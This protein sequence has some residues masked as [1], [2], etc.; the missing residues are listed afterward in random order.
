MKF[1]F[2]ILFFL[3]PII[4]SAQKIERKIIIENGN[5]YFTTIDEEFQ[6]ATLHQ[7]KT[8]DKLKDA[9]HFALPAGRNFDAPVIPFSWDISNGFIYAINFLVHPLNDRNEALKKIKLSALQQWDST[10][11]VTNMLMTSVDLSPFAMND[12]YLFTVNRKNTLSNFYFDGISVNDST[13]CMAITNNNE[14][15]IWEWTGTMWRHSEPVNFQVDGYFSLFK[16]KNKIYA[17][18]RHGFIHEITL[19]SKIGIKSKKIGFAPVDGI[20]IDNRDKKTIQFLNN[21]EI[22]KEIPLNELLK[23][24]AVTIF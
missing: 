6:I 10:V 17:Q 20:L 19:G 9:K 12:P 7:G 13:Y 3:S 1:F 22:N 2:N 23:D 14:I 8:T 4:L 16:F 24:K 11:T 15:S 18:F 21:K 5:F